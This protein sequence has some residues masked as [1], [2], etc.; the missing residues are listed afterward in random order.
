MKKYSLQ[1]GVKKVNFS[2]KVAKNCFISF[3]PDGTVMGKRNLCSC[4]DC[5]DGDL[6][7]CEI[8]KGQI[9]GGKSFEHGSSSDD[10]EESDESDDENSNDSDEEYEDMEIP[11][12]F[13]FEIVDDG[14]FIAI[15]SHSSSIELFYMCKVLSKEI[16]E[17]NT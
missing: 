15:F 4:R 5:L 10:D 13:T 8:E 11:N 17:T 12:A 9:S 7:K 6:N 14:A 2:L 1:K 3:C 16:A